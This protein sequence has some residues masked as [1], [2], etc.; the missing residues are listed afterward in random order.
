MIFILPVSLAIVYIIG[1][2][3]CKVLKDQ[4]GRSLASG[5]WWKKE[6]F[7]YTTRQIVFIFFFNKVLLP[8]LLRAVTVICILDGGAE[9]VITGAVL[10]YCWSALSSILAVETT[11]PNAVYFSYVVY[12]D[13]SDA[14]FVFFISVLCFAKL[15][16]KALLHSLSLHN[17]A[18]SYINR[19]V[20]NK[21]IR[22]VFQNGYLFF[23]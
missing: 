13:H 2:Y 22:Q 20:Y 10:K 19:N 5:C 23:L 16:W 9:L 12:C 4:E 8:H 11:A 1:L 18:R 15:F 14:C 3:Y 17:L 7:F 6:T 21:N